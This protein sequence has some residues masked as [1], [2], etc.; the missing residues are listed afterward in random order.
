MSPE[1]M[2]V[3]A[4]VEKLN[5]ALE[6][7]HR[8]ALQFTLMA[9]GTQGFEY[10]SLVELLRRFAAAELDDTRRLVE[11][12]VAL[13]GEPSCAT[14]PYVYQAEPSA[15]FEALVDNECEAI[16]ALHDVIPDTGQEPRSE[17]L[18]HMI[19]H[20][21]MRKQEQVDVLLRATRRT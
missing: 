4:V 9:G 14:V 1:L 11:K 5:A 6:R 2:D 21:I 7:Q 12:I 15:A 18:E 17:A 13:G 20:A 10:Q 19:E 8:S 16:A 3:S